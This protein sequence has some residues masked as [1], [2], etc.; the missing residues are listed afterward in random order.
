[1]SAPT[2]VR[3]VQEAR[4]RVLPPRD[5]VETG[6]EA[7][8]FYRDKTGR[9]VLPWQENAVV[10]ALAERYVADPYREIASGYRWA[11]T[12][13]GLIVARQNGKGDVLMIIALY[14][15]FVL[16]VRRIFW[17]AQLQKTA[18]DAHKRMAEVIKSSPELLGQLRGGEK[19]IR[20]GKGDERI[21][22][23]DGREII[24]FT[25]SDNAGR[26]LFGDVLILDEAYD[27]TDGELR[28]LRPLLKTSL[29]PMV[30]YTSTPVDGDTMM[31]GVVLSRVRKNAIVRNKPR[32]AWI[33]WS[34][35]ELP[36]KAMRDTRPTDPEMWA[37]ANP[38]LNMW[39]EGHGGYLVS[40]EVLEDDLTSMGVRGFLVEDL[41]APDYWPDPD[42]VET[43]DVPIDSAAFQL[44]ASRGAV[45]LD[46]VVLGLDR[47]PGGNTA[48]T[49]AGWTAD[50]RWASDLVFHRPG[51]DWVVGA[52]LFLVEQFRPAV[53]VLDGASPAAALLPKLLA[54]GID[55]IVTGSSEMGQ[56]AQGFVDDFE[57]GRYTWNGEDMALLS[58]VE[59]ARWRNIGT[60]GVR[61]FDRKGYGDIAPLVS[62]ALAGYG[63][64]QVVIR[65]QE[66]PP[67]LDPEPVDVPYSDGGDGFNPLTV[68]L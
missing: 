33:E 1:V 59:I 8:Q 35:P 29:N 27:L 17:T 24:F 66:L 19:G 48:I 31:N 9:E 28:A 57:E 37:L 51:S 13:I 12:D 36:D 58:S 6:V 62:A 32:L 50:G 61:A 21:V 39:V 67:P 20:S 46:P 11:A 68:G 3:G 25:R 38:S 2:L 34:C 16:G 5:T 53:L 55:P 41:C 63:L 4:I 15:L 54:A 23:Q 40:S 22:M 44:A 43:G 10:D 14:Q 45:L 56:A 49:A 18:T 42:L 26:G 65:D 47:S 30:I 64:R 60:Q 52:I 7:V